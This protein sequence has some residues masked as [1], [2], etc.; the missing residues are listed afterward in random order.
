MY[1]IIGGGGKVGEVLAQQLLVAGHE[2][3][4]V[5]QDG[6]TAN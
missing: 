2:V 1:I 5:E 6:N 4:V 3:V